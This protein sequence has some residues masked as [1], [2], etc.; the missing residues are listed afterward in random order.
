[1]G[2]RIFFSHASADKELVER[3]VDFFVSSM[4]IQRREIFCTSLKGTLPPGKE[5]IPRIKQEIAGCKV[6]VM[7][8]TQAY[9]E[10]PFCLAELG[11]AWAL[12]QEIYPLTVSPVTYKD[13]E[14]TPLKGIQCLD[15]QSEEDLSVLYDSFVKS[16]IA[17]SSE[18]LFRKGLS[19]FL[20]GG[21]AYG[22]TSKEQPGII[23]HAEELKDYI[24][25]LEDQVAKKDVQAQFLLGCIY[26]EG[27]LVP[28]DTRKGI[29]YLREA[30][31]ND[32]P[33]AQYHLSSLYYRG[34]TGK[35]DFDKAFQWEKKAAD[36]RYVPA[37]E[38]LAW[39]YRAGLGCERD[40]EKAKYWYE[41]AAEYGYVG[42]YS[43]LAATCET[44][45][46]DDAVKWWEKAADLND[47]Y[48]CYHLGKLY[49][50][51]YGKQKPNYQKA[52]DLFRRASEPEHN[53]V[54]AQY[55]LGQ[56]YYLGYGFVGRDFRE[57]LRWFQSAAEAGQV[58]SQY[59]TAYQY[60]YGLGVE[61]N[62]D[63][64]I[65]WFEK[66]AAHGH[67]L[68]QVDVANLYASLHTAAGYEKARHWYEQACE[69]NCF[70]AYRKLGDLYFWGL[71]CQADRA[72][73][74]RY[75]RKAAEQ[76]DDI[77]KA[78]LGMGL[79]TIPFEKTG[80]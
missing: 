50:D 65:E 79:K 38:G 24:K 9:L 19:Q 75:Y 39:L 68:S 23:D 56:M 53:Q 57:A 71:G 4:D 7:L 62:I 59:N 66:A 73:A 1:M 30:A 42:A 47:S 33:A 14:R 31:D 61:Q 12:N 13:L 37:M 35:P 74:L 52:A 3:V 46:L 51:G 69:Q 28:Q 34:V 58:D 17:E 40:L 64:A 18:S 80:E 48:A 11:A 67:A 20:A 22:S 36:N 21:P 76:G 43:P 55:E 54:E 78:K 29:E 15:L 2:N 27:I 72:K 70:K 10:S 45:L 63:A 5:F 26:S 8:I 16:E 41:Q 44:L 25:G 6:V 49:K 77:A 32:D 60:Q